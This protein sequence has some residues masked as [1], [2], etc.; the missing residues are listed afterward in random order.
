MGLCV[1]HHTSVPKFCGRRFPLT[2]SLI[3]RPPVLR[4]N[5][6][7]Q[8]YRIVT[9]NDAG[10]F[11]VEVHEGS[12]VASPSIVSIG[13]KR[14]KA[15]I[16][17]FCGHAHVLDVITRLMTDGLGEDQMLVVADLDDTFSKSFRAPEPEDEHGVNLLDR[18]CK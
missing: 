17:S 5:D 15:A 13:G 8:S 1:V 4:K 2:G 18:L 7:G 10:T 6:P 16:C 14:G 9:N 11:N 12:P 3:L